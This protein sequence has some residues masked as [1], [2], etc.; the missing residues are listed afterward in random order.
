M[1]DGSSL[2]KTRFT[3]AVAEVDR[4]LRS[5]DPAVRPLSRERL[6]ARLHA[7]A[8]W[9]L[10]LG[11]D[12][13]EGGHEVDLVVDRAFPRTMPTV[14]LVRPPPLN[15]WP[16]VEASGKLCLWADGVLPG[17]QTPTQIVD[18]TLGKAWK[19]LTDCAS[20]ANAADFLD[21]SLS[22]WSRATTP[23]TPDVWTILQPTGPCREITVLAGR[24][25]LLAA[26]TDADADAWLLNSANM[27]LKRRSHGLLAWLPQALMP[28][29]YPNS[30]SDL[31]KLLADK[32]PEALPVLEAAAVKE[33]QTLWVLLGAETLNG[34]ALAAVALE[35]GRRRKPIDK[36]FRPGKMPGSMALRKWL[37]GC[38]LLRLSVERCDAA[39]VHGRG[40]DPRFEV[41]RHA[42][43]AVLGCGSVGAKVALDLVT[44]GV[45]NIVLVDPQTLKA[46]NA[47]RHV[48]GL[49]HV[50]RAKAL[51]LGT[52]LRRQ[53]PHIL[54]VQAFDDSWEDVHK[55][56]FRFL[57]DCDLVV[58]ALGDWSSEATLNEWHI[59]LGRRM[60]VVYAW[61]EAHAVAGHAVQ[62]GQSGG[63]LA[64]GMLPSGHPHLRVVDWP[65]GVAMLPEPACGGSF[66]PYGPV[67]L[68][69]ATT[70]AS[71]L[72]LDALVSPVTSSRY[73][74]WA[75][76][77]ERV[78]SASGTWTEQWLE[79][80][81]ARTRGGFVEERRWP[82]R[83][84]C[85][86]CGSGGTV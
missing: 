25:Q 79:G 8:G 56:S 53:F 81:Q 80:D 60:P 21:E 5:L 50:G 23:K 67:E 16:H 66:S 38:S 10:P 72:A 74:V 39:W 12:L 28:A 27:A 13:D 47:G 29:E 1:P 6:S 48:L 68:A 78:A 45:G 70:L 4:Y 31:L 58:A 59:G 63:C 65:A 37:P 77:E 32:A 22:Y 43:V 7:E 52:M 17:D 69:F 42:K 34:P 26:D 44:A 82:H 76:R 36:G 30:A 62:I 85:E 83:P 20:G 35:R 19:L 2:L 41:L 18:D 9:R 11:D 73:R 61:T 51:A 55:R 24:G 84:A 46:A 54:S 57:E 86:A 49:A 64:C 71:E 14:Y 33:P 40:R 3:S 75:A 15:T